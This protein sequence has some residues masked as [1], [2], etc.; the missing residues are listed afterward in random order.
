[1][2]PRLWEPVKLHNWKPPLLLRTALCPVPPSACPNPL[3]HLSR[4][5]S[6]WELLDKRLLLPWAL[7][8]LAFSAPG[9]FLY[10]L[11]SQSDHTICLPMPDEGC[12]GFCSFRAAGNVLQCMLWPSIF[13]SCSRRGKPGWSAVSSWRAANQAAAAT[14]FLQIRV[15]VPSEQPLEPAVSTS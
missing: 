2:N 9:S 13:G 3:E 14:C 15:F 12:E 5:S 8:R 1:M 7:Q 4:A 6:N 11:L 10:T